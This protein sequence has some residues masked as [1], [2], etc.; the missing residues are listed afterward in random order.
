LDAEQRGVLLTSLARMS[1]CWWT[2]F[3]RAELEHREGR[4][5]GA[6][7]AEASEELL[8]RYLASVALAARAR[9]LAA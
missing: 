5:E 7:G 1:S 8:G 9:Y 4:E 3:V 2:K 6:G